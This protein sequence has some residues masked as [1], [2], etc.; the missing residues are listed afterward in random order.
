MHR[1]LLLA[2]AAILISSSALAQ[3]S[4]PAKWQ[5]HI[6]AEGKISNDRSIGEGGIFIP[7]WQ[8]SD[9]MVFT[10]IRGRFDNQDS[11]ELNLGLGYRQQINNEWIIGG[12]AFYDRRN[13][14]NENTFHQATI[15][16]EAMST[17]LE[18]RINGYLPENDEKSTSS[19]SSIGVVNGANLQIQNYGTAKERALPGF[20]IEVGKGFKLPENWEFWVYGG[21]FHFDADGYDNVSGPRGRMELSYD[22]VPYLGEGSRFT[23]GMESQTDD[24]RGG[25]TFGIARLR[26]PLSTL[27]RKTID[28]TL[29]GLDKRMTSRI[30][31]DVDIVSDEQAAQIESTEAANFTLEDGTDVT[32]FTTIDANDDLE[33]DVTAAGINTLIVVDGTAGT[34]NVAGD[35]R[36]LDGQSIIGGGT[37]ITVTGATSGS[38]ASLTLPGSRPTINGTNAGADIFFLPAGLS[39][40]TL[41]QNMTLTGGRVGINHEGDDSIIRDIIIQDTNNDGIQFRNNATNTLVEDVTIIRPDGGAEEAIQFDDNAG[42]NLTFRNISIEDA[43]NGFIFADIGGGGTTTNVVFDNVTVDTVVNV[44]VTQANTILTSPSGSITS[45]NV[46][47]ANC[48]NNGAINM[49]TLTI[50][51]ASCP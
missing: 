10:D 48:L 47:G 42:T 17:D 20:D 22:N 31:R 18:F 2:S 14:P 36:P 12:Y 27:T 23:I 15:G 46:G 28:S 34:I 45:T 50:N 33:A 41:L 16:A 51:A 44:I 29:S 35:V 38:T 30:I 43:N 24:E 3:Q 4:T 49:S 19:A 39:D 13:S 5:P 7:V 6:E 40:D 26:V 21:G 11:E 25:Q 32:T 9:R 37:S 1:S 8:E